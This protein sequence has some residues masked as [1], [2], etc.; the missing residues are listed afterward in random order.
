MAFI[1]TFVIMAVKGSPFLLAVAAFQTFTIVNGFANS[2]KFKFIIQINI[3][4]PQETEQMTIV[5]FEEGSIERPARFDLFQI[6]ATLMAEE[7]SNC[8]GIS[9]VCLHSGFILVNGLFDVLIA[10]LNLPVRVPLNSQR[11]IL[12]SLLLL[13]ELALTI[14]L[15]H[16]FLYISLHHIHDK[17][18]KIVVMED[19][20]FDLSFIIEIKQ[21]QMYFIFACGIIFI[22]LKDALLELL[23]TP[24]IVRLT[25]I[26]LPKCLYS[27]LE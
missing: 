23:V 24:Q 12:F 9:F 22:P 14:H 4:T 26:F 10:V 27:I 19:G 3:A 13:F 8:L 7:A 6:L 17:I 21:H 16:Y 11:C 2:T 20:Y 5:L 1:I 18:G 15:H 25:T